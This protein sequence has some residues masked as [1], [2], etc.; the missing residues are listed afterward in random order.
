MEVFRA[1]GDP[2]RWSIVCQ[3]ADVDELPCSVLEETLEVSRPTISYHT[4]LLSQAG[5][6]TVRRAGRNLYYTL[7]REVLRA[8]MDDLWRLAPTPTPVVDG[9]VAFHAMPTRRRAAR[10]A[11]SVEAPPQREAAILTW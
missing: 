10:A 3:M 6:I 11:A 7:R 4:K 1:L 8:L 5:L 9:E 2:V